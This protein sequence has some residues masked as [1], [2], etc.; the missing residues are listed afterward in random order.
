LINKVFSKGTLMPKIFTS[1]SQRTGQF[2]E[3]IAVR[4]LMDRG[5]TIIE[6]NYTK[7][8]GEIDIIAQKGGVVHFIEVKSKSVLDCNAIPK[9]GIRPEEGMHPRKINRIKRTLQTYLIERNVSDDWKFDVVL[10][11]MS[12]SQRQARVELMENIIL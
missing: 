5:F 12:D 2:G 11:Y 7:K 4:Y 3:N 6:R 1:K 8:W 10:V 9:N